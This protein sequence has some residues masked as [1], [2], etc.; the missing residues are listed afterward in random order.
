M[1]TFKELE[2]STDRVIG[3][4]DEYP[5]GFIDPLHSH[6]RA[7]L[8][9]A[10]SGVMAV[11]VPSAQF[12]I[13]PQR[14]LWLP[15]GTPHAVRCRGAV[16]LRTLYFPGPERPCGVVEVS[17]FLQALILEVVGFSSA[18]PGSRERRITDLLLD[19]L[20]TMP[21]APYGIPMPEDTRLLR[22]CQSLLETPAERRDLDAWSALAGMGRR[23]FTR[24]F[25]QATGMGLGQWRQQASLMEALCLLGTGASVAETAFSLGYESPSAFTALFRRHFG[26]PPS[27]HHAL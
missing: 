20:Q 14:A 26:V 2:A 21:E 16:S 1:K 11:T 10:S 5:P 17:A 19:E 7:Q 8:L 18:S 3:L 13:P 12:I 25:K 4:A 15:G 23:T 27:R 9:Y 22:V 6:P 24:H